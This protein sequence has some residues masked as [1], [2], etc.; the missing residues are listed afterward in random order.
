MG[1]KLEGKPAGKG[2]G[3]RQSKEVQPGKTGGL[4]RG[5]VELPSSAELQYDLCGLGLIIANQLNIPKPSKPGNASSHFSNRW[6]LVCATGSPLHKCFM[7]QSIALTRCVDFMQSHREDFEPFLD[8][9]VE[10]L[11]KGAID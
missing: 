5:G 2:V 6:S 4:V 7:L 10:G 3:E 8:D 11:W 9:D 1:E